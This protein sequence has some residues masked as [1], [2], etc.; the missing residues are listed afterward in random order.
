M[1]RS[2]YLVLEALQR[3]I[4]RLDW[5]LTQKFKCIGHAL[6]SAQIEL[7]SWRTAKASG[8][9]PTTSSRTYMETRAGLRNVRLGLAGCGGALGEQR[10]DAGPQ[11][12]QEVGHA[13]WQ[14]RMPDESTTEV[15]DSSGTL[16]CRKTWAVAQ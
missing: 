2:G 4:Q 6:V 9:E 13:Q 7:R 5:M 12:H 14:S 10:R 16:R 8:A 15:V 3:Q 1:A 11:L